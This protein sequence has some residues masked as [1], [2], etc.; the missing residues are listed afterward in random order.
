MQDEDGGWTKWVTNVVKAAVGVAATATAVAI[1][2]ATGGAA[3]PVLLGVATSTAIGAAVGYATGGKQG[4]IDGAA[5]GLLT[6]GVTALAGATIKMVAPKIIKAVK[7]SQ[8]DPVKQ[9]LKKLDASGIRPG[10]TE[11][12]RSKVMELVQNFDSSKAKSSIY[13]SGK[14]RYLV[15]GHH[16]TVAATILGRGTCA[17]MG[18]TTTQVPSAL[19][20]YWYKRWYQFGRTVI[21]IRK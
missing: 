12:R 1:T 6:G 4:A 8:S 10:Q 14:T 9:A 17:G 15:E 21:K 2:V 11:I 16:T 5:N 7:S 19:N 18:V 3:A 20:V 13:V